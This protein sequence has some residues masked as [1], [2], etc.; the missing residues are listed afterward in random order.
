ML[1]TFNEV[2]MTAVMEMRKKY[3]DTFK[4]KY[5]IGLGFMSIFTK[6]VCEAIKEFPAVNSDVLMILTW[7]IMT[8]WIWA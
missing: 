5:G 2:D 6:A 3:K 7:F 8:L 1:T 4:D